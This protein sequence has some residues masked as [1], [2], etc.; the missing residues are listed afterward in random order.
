MT[1]PDALLA[2]QEVMS[3]TE[4]TPD[5]LDRVAEILEDAGYEIE[6]TN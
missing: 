3:G 2:I 1:A 6:D 5:T 4:W